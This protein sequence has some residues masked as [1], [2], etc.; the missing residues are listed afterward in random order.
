MLQ[1]KET[2]EVKVKARK[3]KR[4]PSSYYLHPVHH[5]V[6]LLNGEKIVDKML[7]VAPKGE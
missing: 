3:R 7:K 6:R 4:S 2:K 5:Q 1:Q